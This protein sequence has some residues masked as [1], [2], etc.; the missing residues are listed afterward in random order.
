MSPTGAHCFFRGNVATSRR[1][2]A[3]R[4][5]PPATAHTPKIAAGITFDPVFG[6]VAAGAAVVVGAG[7]RAALRGDASSTRRR[8]RRDRGRAEHLHRRRRRRCGRGGLRHRSRGRDLGRGRRRGR[9]ARRGRGRVPT[10]RRDRFPLGEPAAAGAANA[11]TARAPAPAV[12]SD[13]RT[14]RADVRCVV[15]WGIPVPSG[16][17]RHES[18]DSGPTVSRG[19]RPRAT[20]LSAPSPRDLTHRARD[21]ARRDAG[22]ASVVRI[23]RPLRSDTRMRT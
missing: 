19:R 5:A 14:I 10:R 2:R 12:A 20:G 1:R 23:R 4:S 16:R 6:S 17:G 9:R 21:L 7:E 11:T 18:P 15:C 22:Y 3:R 13:V 8:S